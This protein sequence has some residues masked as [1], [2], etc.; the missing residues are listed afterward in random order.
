M[1]KP[2]PKPKPTASKNTY[3]YRILLTAKIGKDACVGKVPAGV[4]Q[5]AWINFQ[6]FCCFEDLAKFLQEKEDSGG[7]LNLGLT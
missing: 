5:E 1:K 4:D 7:S 2:K 6:L 3:L